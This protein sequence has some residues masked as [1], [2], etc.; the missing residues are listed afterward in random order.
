MRCML[1]CSLLV[2]RSSHFWFQTVTET[3]LFVMRLPLPTF[4][5]VWLPTLHAMLP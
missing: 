5:P 2:W 1:L 3:I 4:N